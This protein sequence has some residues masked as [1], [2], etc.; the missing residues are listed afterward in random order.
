MKHY[1]T[2]ASEANS[3]LTSLLGFD[4]RLYVP[5]ILENHDL[6]PVHLQ[7][8]FEEFE[9]F[10]FEASYI[11]P[12]FNVDQT[13][14]EVPCFFVKLDGYSKDLKK[15]FELYQIDFPDQIVQYG[16]FYLLERLPPVSLMNQLKGIIFSDKNALQLLSA[17]DLDLL[18]HLTARK[19]MSFL[20]AVLM[21][22]ERYE[23]IQLQNP[24]NLELL[25]SDVLLASALSIDSKLLDAFQHWDYQMTPPKCLIQLQQKKIPN[26]HAL[27][28][29]LLLQALGFDV[30]IWSEKGYA[31]I[32]NRF[33]TEVI[34]KFRLEE[35]P[36]F[37]VL[38]YKVRLVIATIM[39]FILIAF[40][41][42]LFAEF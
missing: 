2:A 18:K 26:S 39:A 6:S 14:V 10:L 35:K 13:V 12:A 4:G 17:L 34:S 3:E 22:C 25:S 9:H 29:L 19:R 40:M 24:T 30:V 38:D 42:Y 27:L 33:P 16:S 11:R 15:K 41:V 23:H 21:S 5:E 7:A 32:E 31:S 36:K 28:R 8:S 20:A 1:Q 37:P